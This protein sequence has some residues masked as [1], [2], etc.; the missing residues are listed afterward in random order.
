M[1]SM[2]DIARACKVSVSTVSRAL[3]GVPGI[4]TRQVELIR[5]TARKMGYI[6]NEVARTLKTSRS[7]MIAVL[8]DAELVHPFFSILL[9]AIRAEAEE[10][11]YDL[12]FLSR[13]GRNGRD[14]SDSALCRATDGVVIVYA[15]ADSLS[16]RKLM[17]SGIPVVSVDDLNHGCPLVVSDYRQGTRELVRLAVRR[18][19]RRIALIHGEMG[20]ATR[21]RVEGFR[22]EM[23]ASGLAVPEGMIRPSFFQNGPA[24][25]EN[26]RS[27]LALPEPPTC[28]LL[29]DDTSAVDAI[30][31]LRDEGLECPRDFSCMGYDGTAAARPGVPALTTFRQDF[32]GIAR[33]TV[34]LLLSLTDQALPEQQDT[35]IRGRVLEGVTLASL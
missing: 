23:E 31:L 9:D 1:V 35:V 8:Y 2:K 19:H 30:R 6:P 10:Y 21:E 25:A 28:I 16:P 14:Y 13:K 24:A 27:L 22:E 12:I 29:Q 26:I 32:R 15:D 20:Y 33:E 5:Q 11:G 4:S 7:W 34:R 3:N 17:D 18:G